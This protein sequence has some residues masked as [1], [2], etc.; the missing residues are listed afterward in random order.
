MFLEPTDSA[1]AGERAEAPV[2]RL[3][4]LASVELE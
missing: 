1:F 4:I 2:F 3:L